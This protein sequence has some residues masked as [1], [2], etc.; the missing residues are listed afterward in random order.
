MTRRWM[1][2]VGVLVAAGCA[3]AT[4]VTKSDTPAAGFLPSG[5]PP[6]TLWAGAARVEMTSP[7]GTPLAGYRRRHGR[8]STGVHDPLYARSLALSDGE[9]VV[10]LVSCELLIIDEDLYQA[11]L[12]RVERHHHIGRQGLML[13]ATHTHS[14]PGGYGHHFLEQLSMGRYDAR[15]FE[16]LSDRIAEAALR[17]IETLQPAAVRGGQAIVEGASRNRLQDGGPTD[18]AVRALRVDAATGTPL[19]WLVTFAA[20]PTVLGAENRFFSG[21]YPGAL[22]AS[23][24]R[25]YPQSTCLFAVGAIADQAPVY[26]ESD[27]LDQAQQLGERLAREAV[28][29]INQQAPVTQ[30]T[31]LAAIDDLSLPPARLRVGWWRLPAWVSERFLDRYARLHA[32]A[33]G[34]WLLLGA[35]CD[36]S[37]AIGR[38]MSD[39]ARAHGWTPLIIGFADDYIGYVLPASDYATRSYEARMSFNGPA[40]AEELTRALTLIIE[41]LTTERSHATTIR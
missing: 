40:I 18:P 20:H 31:I 30:A 14:G 1:V 28:Q 26:T 35:P 15:V 9:R 16:Q 10:V 37:I 12:E 5:Q 25:Q 41:R 38:Q 2:L 36:M 24:E 7:V 32:V 19:A 34:R 23:V 33:V 4:A 3:R 11:V 6:Q 8:P 27:R 21:D 13:W 17:A 22:M 29:A 39:I